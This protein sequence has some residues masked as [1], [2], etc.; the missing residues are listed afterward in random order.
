MGLLAGKPPASIGAKGGRLAPCRPSPN[1]VSS[2]ANRAS[3]P[4]HFIEPLKF[5]G[6]PDAVWSALIEILKRAERASI[7]STQSSYLHAEFTSR[8]LGFVDDVEFL[9]DAKARL[10]HVRSASRLG[11]RDFGVNRERIEMIRELLAA[12][13]T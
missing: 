10:I 6:A 5:S 9:L 11:Y 4:T 13:R 3:D 7:V 2:Q 8:W 12:A 1:C